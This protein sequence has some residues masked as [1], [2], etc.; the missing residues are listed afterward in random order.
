MKNIDGKERQQSDSRRMV[1]AEGEA[2]REVRTCLEMRGK[3]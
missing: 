2:W 3:K 1:R